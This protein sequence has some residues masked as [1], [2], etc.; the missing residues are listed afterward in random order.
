VDLKRV[1]MMMGDNN[2][3]NND[4][5]LGEEELDQDMD[6]GNGKRL[7]GKSEKKDKPSGTS[8]TQSTPMSSRREIDWVS[9]QN[10]DENRLLQE[11][12]VGQYSCTKLLR[13]MGLLNQIL[14][15]KIL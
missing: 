2:D 13:E 12:E 4:D 1:L 6:R 15:E 14:R 10:N 5:D 7:D 3:P 11:T 9:F 8:G